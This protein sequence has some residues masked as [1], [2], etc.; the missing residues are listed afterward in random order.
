MKKINLFSLIAFFL[1]FIACSSNQEEVAEVLTDV[2][3]TSL[4][5]NSTTTTSVPD[6]TTT[7]EVV[8][9]GCI[10]EDNSGINFDELQNVQNFLNRYGFE[11]GV[12]DGLEGNQTREA[13]KRFQAYVGITVDGDLGPTTFG[14]MK[15]YTG[16]ET[17]VN[18]Y[19]TVTT[20]T[21]I[22]KEET[23]TTVS[24]TTTVPTTTT[25]VITTNNGYGFQGIVS[26]ENGNFLEVLTSN[27]EN[28]SFC[29]GVAPTYS[30]QNQS[31]DLGFPPIYNLYPSPPSLTAGATTQ[32]TSNSSTTFTIQINGNG[33]KNFKFYFIE[34]FTSSYV[35]LEPI[36][37]STSTGL[38]E[39]TFSKSGLTNGYWFYGY[40]DN[41]NGGLV[42]A[43]GLREFLVGPAVV[44]N[45]VNINSFDN[46][47]I[48]TSQEVISNGEYIQN[49]SEMYITYIMDT[50]FNAF[51]TI[52]NDVNTSDT[53]ITV[54]SSD[55]YYIGDIILIDNEL[56]KIINITNQTFTVERGFNNSIIQIHGVG[57]SVQ[58]LVT[59]TDMKAVRGYALFRGEKGYSFSVSLGKEG[60]PTKFTISDSCPKDLYSLEYIKVFA[61]REKG[62]ST[63]KT[64]DMTSANSIISN[65]KFTLYQGIEDY[66]FPDMFA[67]DP[68]NGQFLNLGPREEIYTVGD[69][70]NFD[71]SGIV[72][73][74]NEIKYIEL[75]F[76]MFP[77]GSKSTKS[78]KIVFSPTDNTYRY[79]STVVSVSDGTV[80][81]NNAWESGYRYVLSHV[82][83]NDGVSEL[84]FKSN[85]VLE[86]VTLNSKSTHSVYYLDQFSFTIVD[87]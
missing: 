3:P 28:N 78:R 17:R 44:Q 25:T 29:S 71:F 15:S 34:P 52:S 76:D 30:E 55:N 59:D 47:W 39:A 61:W 46:V 8:Y 16:C 51:S 4:A 10:P 48:N 40:A 74:S 42:K 11:A 62:E 67:S 72:S 38:T 14:K 27:N 35:L 65:D 83:I 85:S 23:S 37:I 49:N 70:I 41:G 20:T 66:I 69:T 87:S 2:T 54:V 9:D 43:D 45:D 73:G 75:A 86:N 84:I 22:V 80:F 6:T 18:E 53:S 57:T 33:D 21:T 26:P 1:I 79:S 31:S 50:G 68:S 56:M 24:T 58:K 77:T 19:V 64:I 36:N 82:K 13:I 7:T 63:I 12:E 5:T 32:I 81:I 60:I